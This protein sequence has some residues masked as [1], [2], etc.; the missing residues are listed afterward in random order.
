MEAVECAR[1]SIW[2][3]E[4]GGELQGM[5]CS[6]AKH[7]DEPLVDDAEVITAPA[8]T[9]YFTELAING[10]F[11]SND[12]ESDERLKA[13]RESYLMKHGIRATL[14]VPIGINGRAYWLVC[15]EQLRGPHTWPTNHVVIARQLCARAG[16]LISRLLDVRL[17]DLQSVPFPSE[18]SLL[19]S[20]QKGS[21]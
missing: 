12:V 7:R 16:L 8:Y 21:D 1:L 2:H 10:Y 4:V 13:M 19:P 3:F 9:S 5:R 14:D 17:T 20:M 6:W 15:C 11:V 18:V